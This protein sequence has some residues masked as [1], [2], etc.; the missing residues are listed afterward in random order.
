M[1]TWPNPNQNQYQQRRQ[2]FA[3]P[4]PGMPL[5]YAQGE[6]VPQAVARFFNAVYAWMFA[7]LALTAVVAWYVSQNI[8]I[9]QRLGAGIWVLFIIE[10]VLVG[11]VS[12]AIRRISTP[13]ATALF[14]LYAALNG[15]TLSVIF[16]VYAHATL[17]SA[18]A[19]TAGT[20][21]A[22]SLYGVVTR[23]DLS[24]MG[25]LLF[26]G[27]IGLV[28]ATFANLFFHLP[29]LSMVVNY[30]GVLL[31]VGLTAYDTQM[32][33]N[34]AIQTSGDPALAA[35]LSVSG[36]LSLYLDF[37]NMFLFLLRIMGDRR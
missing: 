25:S 11:T 10:L 34:I 7:G 24:G 35:R 31:F 18:F 14:L 15:V 16:L 26:M 12:A 22:M 17:A 1:S 37:L 5:D 6:A 33:K 30:V 32:L 2:G 27:L 9:L 29:G 21:G 20:F 3:P 23:R 28:L 19:V 8:E 36:A 13:V 4:A